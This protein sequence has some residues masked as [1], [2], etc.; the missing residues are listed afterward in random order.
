MEKS[1][2]A[3][4]PD[5]GSDP[6]R[7]SWDVGAIAR[8]LRQAPELCRD[9]AHGCGV[10]YELAEGALSVELFPPQGERHDGIVRL[11]MTDARQEFYRQPQPAIGED[12]L[13][14]ETRELVVSLSPAGDV[15]T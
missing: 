14:F 9:V 13:V 11:S 5:D 3:P 1:R 12:G 6:S 2:H 15:M 7:R 8:A 4:L 10:R